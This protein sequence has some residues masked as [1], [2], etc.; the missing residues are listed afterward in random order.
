MSHE[1]LVKL[2]EKLLL[3]TKVAGVGIWE[4]CLHYTQVHHRQCVAYYVWHVFPNAEPTF[5]MWLEL[6]HHEDRERFRE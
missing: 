6:V 5:E 4:Y 2:S 1:D 3:A